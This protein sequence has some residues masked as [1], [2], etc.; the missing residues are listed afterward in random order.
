MKAR[1]MAPPQRGS[2][3]E[4]ARAAVWFARVLPGLTG[5]TREQEGAPVPVG[6][7]PGRAAHERKTGRS[8][9]MRE[10]GKIPVGVAAIGII[11]DQR[12]PAGASTRAISAT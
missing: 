3:R 1:G 10:L 4:N 12:R 6:E 5:R 2:T 8:G 9:V 7:V 11:D